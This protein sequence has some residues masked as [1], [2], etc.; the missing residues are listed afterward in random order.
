MNIA[1]NIDRQMVGIFFEIKRSLPFE[2]RDAMKI[3]A[4]GMGKKLVDIYKKSNSKRL[5]KLIEKFMHR[6]GDDWAKKLKTPLRSKLMMY[7]G[8]AIEKSLYRSSKN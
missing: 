8:Q 2:E 1:L 3:A 4:P 5:K 7:R 6:A